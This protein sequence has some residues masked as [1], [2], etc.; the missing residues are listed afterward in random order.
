MEAREVTDPAFLDP[1]DVFDIH[2]RRLARS[3][4]RSRDTLHVSSLSGSTE[5]TGRSHPRPRLARG[6]VVRRFRQGRIMKLT[7][8]LFAL[9]GI[10]ALVLS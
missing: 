10:A 8:A 1:G 2:D 9:L 3:D 4:A 7:Q 6:H 5:E